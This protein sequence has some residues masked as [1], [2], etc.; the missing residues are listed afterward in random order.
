M[1]PTQYP[2]RRRVWT[3]LHASCYYW[4][5]LLQILPNFGLVGRISE[6]RNM[7][8][9]SGKKSKENSKCERNKMAGN[10]TGK[11]TQD[12]V[13]ENG[14]SGSSRARDVCG[15]CEELVTS[16]GKN[17]DGLYCDYCNCWYHASCEGMST[18]TYQM[19]SKLASQIHNMSYYCDFNHCK[20]V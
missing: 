4:S 14:A 7:T 19:F 1:I 17:S 18:D 12:F 13:D 2:L 15:H 3:C 6:D 20:I 11:P 10:M 5:F 8:S 16:R 9:T